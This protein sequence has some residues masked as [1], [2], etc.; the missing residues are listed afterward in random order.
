[1]AQVA[2]AGSGR[3]LLRWSVP[4]AEIPYS[5]PPEAIYATLAAGRENHQ[6]A[7]EDR[8]FRYCAH[9]RRTGLRTREAATELQDAL[10]AANDAAG[11]APLPPRKS[12]GKQSEAG[13]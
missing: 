8:I 13:K 9:L 2:S 5:G 10:I 12:H 1:L 6:F 4:M 7:I 11:L 3:T